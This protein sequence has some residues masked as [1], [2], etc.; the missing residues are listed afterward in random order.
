MTL[1]AHLDDIRA[2]IDHIRNESDVTM[3]SLLGASFG[4]G[5]CAHY[6]VSNPGQLARLV[7]LNPQLNCKDRYV[8]QNRIGPM[9][10]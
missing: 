10:G 1:C 3:V 7:L 9:I 4:G 6:A 5:L 8:D 2:A